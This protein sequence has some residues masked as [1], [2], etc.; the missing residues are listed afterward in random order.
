[1]AAAAAHAAVGAKTWHH[2]DGSINSVII[3]KMP[4][5]DEVI[6]EGSFGRKAVRYACTE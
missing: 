4:D 3:S 6:K 2:L 1:M 5:G